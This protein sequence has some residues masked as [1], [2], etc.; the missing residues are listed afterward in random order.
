MRVCACD[1][2]VTVLL[3]LTDPWTM[4]YSKNHKK[5]FFYNKTTKDSTFSM[6]P[7]SVTPFRYEVPG[8]MF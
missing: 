6:P 3:F 5:K 7:S 1:G 2:C 8:V 4:A